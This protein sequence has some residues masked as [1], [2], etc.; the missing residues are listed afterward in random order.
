MKRTRCTDEQ[1][2][3]ILVE[4]EAVAKC[5]DLCREHGMSEGTFY[6]WKAKFGG[7]TVSEAKRLK[8]L[9][10]EN[11]KL[12]KLLAEQMLDLAAMKDLV[13]KNGRARRQARSR[14]VS[15]GRTWPVGAAG[16]PS[17]RGRS[18]NGPVS[19]TADTALRGRLPELAN[20]R[21]RFGCRR[22]FVL[23]R[24]EGGPSG[25]NRIYRLYRAEGLTVRKRKARGRRS[26]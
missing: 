19:V 25:I 8:V 7:M 22:L 3:G 15:A 5:A 23:L 26:L 12:K 16:L 21:R 24:R 17:R 9:E 13:L 14:C 2:I 6:N 10:D 1:L 18:E 4:H 11:A 20:G